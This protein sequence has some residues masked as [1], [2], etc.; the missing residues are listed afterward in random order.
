[1]AKTTIPTITLLDDVEKCEKEVIEALMAIPDGKSARI[2]INS[3]GGSVYAAL[4]ISTI[5]RM[6]NIQAEAVVLADCSSSALLVFAACQVRK[7]AGHASFL[8]HPMK[9]SSE[10]AA[11]LNGA[12]SWASEFNRVNRVT[13]NWLVENLPI[14]RRLLRRW[15]KEERYVQASELIDL[16]VAEELEFPVDKVIDISVSTKRRPRRKAAAKTVRIRKAS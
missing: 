14:D 12:E 13:E 8:F 16:G 3:G 5:I 10:E 9:W 7:V 4:G 2:I 11:R 15:I 6:K 1:M